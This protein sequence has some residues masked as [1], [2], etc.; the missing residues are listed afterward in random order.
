MNYYQFLGYPLLLVGALEIILGILVLQQNPTRSP[1][2]KYV[3]VFSFSSAGYCL[4]TAIMYVRVAHGN[5]DNDFFARASWIGW[6]SVPAALQVL[7]LLHDEKSRTARVIGYVLYPLWTVLLFLTLFTDLVEPSGYKLSPYID[8]HGPLENPA[9]ALGGILILWI[10]VESYLLQRR[11]VGVKKQQIIHFAVGT[12]IFAGGALILAALIQLFGGF[13]LDP[14]LGA[15]FSF[16]WAFLTFYAIMRYSLFDIRIIVSR[17]VGIVLLWIGLIIFQ[18]ATYHILAGSIGEDLAIVITLSLVASVLYGLPVNR[19]TQAW[20]RRVIVKDAYQ[21]QN[22]LNDSIKAILTILDQDKLIAFIVESIRQS[23]GARVA[24]IYRMQPDGQ[25]VRLQGYGPLME[26]G[27]EASLPPEQSRFIEGTNRPVLRDDPSRPFEDE[28]TGHLSTSLMQ[29]IGADLIVPFVHKSALK[30]ILALGPRNSREP[31]RQSDLDLLETLAGH[32]AMAM[33]NANLYEEAKRARESLRES[34]EKFR[35]L[36]NT[37]PAGIFIHRGERFLY[38]NP[39]VDRLTGYSLDEILKMEL[40][41]VAHPD[42]RQEI[43]E[44]GRTLLEGGQQPPQYEF[45]IVKKDGEERW[46]LMTAGMIEYEGK[47]A[48]IGTIFDITERKQA[49]EERQRLNEENVRQYRERIEEETRHQREKEKILRDLHDGIGGITTNISLLA[50][51]ARQSDVVADIKN[52]LGTISSLA[53]EGLADVRGF[54]H[55]LDTRD[56]TWQSFTAELRSQGK[57]MLEPH[58]ISYR[59]QSRFEGCDAAPGSLLCLNLFRIY[60]EAMTNIIKHSRAKSVSADLEISPEKVMLTISDDGV[61]LKQLGGTGRGL[62]NMKTRSRELGGE[63]SITSG[64]GSSIRV[65]VPLIGQAPVRD[66]KQ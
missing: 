37:L 59:F 61:G 51:M 32:T 20:A 8:Q 52:T 38:A 56:L 9:R 27:G 30:G 1:I 28:K 4:F 43:I 14:G 21:Y 66:A 63:V 11:A 40:W 31:Y 65:E 22:V 62:A 18:I 12:A 54:M 39:A 24:Y 34:E 47:P 26:S 2:N 41:G 7:H 6:F 17:T 36:A 53:R 23:M 16:P 35:A 48:V 33:E 25:L 57:S 15:F 45:K 60:K 58:G 46:V 3:A 29:R 50:E 55:S 5:Y 10:I 64:N 42:Y 19:W 13:G 44:R 49:D